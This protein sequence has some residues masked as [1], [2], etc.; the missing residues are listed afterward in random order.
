[1]ARPQQNLQIL[2]G[3]FITLPDGSGLTTSFSFSLLGRRLGW[4]APHLS[5]LLERERKTFHWTTPT[6]TTVPSFILFLPPVW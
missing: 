4:G 1:M 2:A 3:H 6:T 5:P